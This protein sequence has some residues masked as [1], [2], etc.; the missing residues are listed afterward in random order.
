[1]GPKYV[2]SLWQ[3]RK[4]N[5]RWKKKMIQEIEEFNISMNSAFH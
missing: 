5:L 4:W 2:V 3:K 1:M